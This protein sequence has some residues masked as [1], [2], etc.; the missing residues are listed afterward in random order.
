MKDTHRNTQN[1][2]QNAALNVDLSKNIFCIFNLTTG[3]YIL[4]NNMHHT[5]K[6]CHLW[7]QNLNKIFLIEILRI[8]LKLYI[9][10]LQ[11]ALRYQLT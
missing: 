5:H 2:T 8:T 6:L 11:V 4:Y 10:F 3:L 1:A 9:T 7:H